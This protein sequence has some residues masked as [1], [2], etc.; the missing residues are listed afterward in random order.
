[1]PNAKV[2]EIRSLG[3]TKVNRLVRAARHL[4]D[5]QQAFAEWANGEIYICKKT[6]TY[7]YRFGD[8][9]KSVTTWSKCAQEL[10]ESPAAFAL[11]ATVLGAEPA[12]AKDSNVRLIVHKLSPAEKVAGRGNIIKLASVA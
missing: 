10:F 12:P 1:M 5:L 3:L 9:S 2:T 4:D 7:R 6:G 8:K 11:A